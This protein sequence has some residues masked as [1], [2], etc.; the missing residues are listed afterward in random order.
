MHWK[1]YQLDLKILSAGMSHL[2]VSVLDKFSMG[3]VR[4]NNNRT[5]GYQALFP[6]WQ[7][8]C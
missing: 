7:V 8:K 5:L 2:T 3:L 6:P 4:P 1:G